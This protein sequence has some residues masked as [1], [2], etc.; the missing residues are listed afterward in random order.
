MIQKII[1]ISV[2]FIILFALNGCNKMG[3][4][5][6]KGRYFL[7]KEDGKNFVIGYKINEDNDFLILVDLY[8]Y[9]TGYN[10]NYIVAIQHPKIENKMSGDTNYYIIPIYN[11]FTYSPK[12]GIIGPLTWKEYNIKKRELKINKINWLNW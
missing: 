7:K 12:N 5:D 1:T 6:I 9:E 3:N 10:D 2:L 8:V 11:N 4:I